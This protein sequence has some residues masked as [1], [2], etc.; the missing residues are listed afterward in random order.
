M[1]GVGH[2]VVPSV[3]G[4]GRTRLAAAASAGPR[5]WQRATS[6]ESGMS[7]P[8]QRPATASCHKPH[9]PQPPPTTDRPD[10]NRTGTGRLGHQP[11]TPRHNPHWHGPPRPATSDQRP[12]TSDQ[13]PRTIPVRTVPIRSAPQGDTARASATACAGRR[14]PAP[15]PRPETGD[16]PPRSRSRSRSRRPPAPRPAPAGDRQ[17]RS[18]DRRPETVNVPNA[19]RRPGR[20]TAGPLLLWPAGDGDRDTKTDQRHPTGASDGAQPV[21]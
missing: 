6:S 1:V 19:H 14:P 18:R 16:R 3:A 8:D 4:F 11:R 10:T 21:R 15:K 2:V 5:S 9:S 13:R 7:R 20:E 12:A 17:R